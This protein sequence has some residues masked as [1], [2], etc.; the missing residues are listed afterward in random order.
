MNSLPVWLP[1]LGSWLSALFLTGLMWIS[2]SLT[3]HLWRWVSWL[4]N[5]SPKIGYLAAALLL[6][7]PI[8]LIALAHHGLHRYLDQFYPDSRSPE[9]GPATGFLPGLMSWWEGLYGWWVSILASSAATF[10]IGIIFTPFS[11]SSDLW[12][13]LLQ[14]WHSWATTIARIMIAALLYQ[15]EYSVRRH[16]ITTNT[17]R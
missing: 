10:I 9:V 8:A 13:W 5:L 6:L 12:L 2:S 14:S 7:S 16:L 17:T 1:N 15:F 3:G 11:V 4:I